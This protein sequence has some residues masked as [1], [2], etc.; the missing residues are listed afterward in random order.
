MDFVPVAC[1]NARKDNSGTSRPEMRERYPKIDDSLQ[2]EDDF[3][4]LENTECMGK[5][6]KLFN[7]REDGLK[8]LEEMI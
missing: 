7:A 6:S 8:Q 5:D 3:R 1:P 2:L 4:A